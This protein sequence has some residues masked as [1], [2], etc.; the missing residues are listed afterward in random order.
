MKSESRSF[1]MAP[2][3]LYDVITRQ[4][5][6]ISKAWLEAIMNSVDAGATKIE[7]EITSKTT[8]IVDDGRGM[9]KE[10]VLQYFEI[11]G[12][13]IEK[14]EKKVYG[15]FRM[16][17]GQLFAFGVNTWLTKNNKMVVDVK[18]K[19]LNYQLEENGLDVEGCRIEVTHYNALSTS[20]LKERLEEIIMWT[21]FVPAELFING[22][23]VKSE[24]EYD[25][26]KETEDATFLLNR[27]NTVMV[28]NLGI[29]VK[30]LSSEGVSGA[31]ISKQPLKLNF[32]RNDIQSDCNIWKLIAKEYLNAKREAFQKM[33]YL[34]E[35]AKKA[36]LRLMY[37]HD[38]DR[39]IFEDKKVF[40]TANGNWT[41]YRDL[42]V[43][44]VAFA[45]RGNRVA[46]RIMQLN[47]NVV[48]LDKD[49]S[50]RGNYTVKRN[51]E[52]DKVSFEELG[53]KLSD[54]TKEGNESLLNPRQKKNMWKLRYFMSQIYTGK[55]REIF[56]GE[57]DVYDMWTNGVDK[58]SVTARILNVD[59]IRFTG[60]VWFS[61][62]HELAH[63]SDSMEAN[64]HGEN[65][66]R[67]FHDICLEYGT[68]IIEMEFSRSWK[69]R[70]N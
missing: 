34:N 29:F 44:K 55:Q 26:N 42:K 15:E 51:S 31:I 57:S 23:E 30:E 32:A 48:V 54:L 64:I 19:G 17:R 11:F 12:E 9:S 63:D 28:Y 47:Q 33:P 65:F 18:N 8:V 67:R 25:F 40:R 24:E 43:Q 4:A 35:E 59:R 52:I 21:R 62:F 3:L 60:F 45:N 69:G 39:E 36:I 27:G 20:D 56:V 16:G 7:M 68:K 61:L 50:W 13:P 14:Q 53:K 58:I 22:E 6:S 37:L 70:K 10:E 1:R 49:F 41:S 38:E 2:K 66:Y 46:D 5:G